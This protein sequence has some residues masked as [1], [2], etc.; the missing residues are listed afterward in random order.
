MLLRGRLTLLALVV[1][2]AFVLVAMLLSASGDEQVAAA[3]VAVSEGPPAPDAPAAPAVSAAR[4]LS[5]RG[6][7][8]AE[9]LAAPSAREEF[10]GLRI[11]DG[12]LE[13]A[14]GRTGEMRLR[15]T[16]DPELSAAVWN[17]LERGRFALAHVVV[18]DPA[19]GAVLAYAST[20][21]E[22]FPPDRTYPAASLVK[23]ITAAAT[24]DRAP[25]AAH[26]TCHF[27]GSPWRLTRE[28]LRSPQR[29]NEADM[30]KAL[31]TSNNQCF[32]RW[33]VHRVGPNALLG[34][35]D[36]FGMLTA[37]A[38]GH[39]GGQAKT[40]SDELALG[41]LGS[42][43][44]GLEIT[45]LHAAQLAATLANGRLVRPRWVA[46]A[47]NADGQRV[48][49]PVGEGGRQVLTPA[50]AAQL[51]GWLV[52]TTVRG[53]ARRAFRVRGG[54][55]L[56]PGISVAGKTGS[57]NG[58]DPKGH[59]EW[60]IGVA[61]ADAPRIAIATVAVQGP[62][63]WWSASQLAAEVLRAT[64]CPRGRCSPDAVDRLRGPVPDAPPVAPARIAQPATA[65]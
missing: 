16:L 15:Y 25:Q 27:L 7:L 63:W 31:A 2:P 60:F 13:R 54:R 65:G 59:Y 42:G 46:E 62:R 24:L 4:A 17:L 49:V 37:P 53:T 34:A 1:L 41:E 57:L 55:P 28:R 6:R 40:P 29:G 3:A 36:R 26:E 23:V 18:M 14:S 38:F 48:A 58:T 45:P 35:I 11:V 21:P 19:T 39:P 5:P 50:L 10:D 12:H 47:W 20:D 9:L 43:L 32:A 52:D 51:R 64:F 22:R 61:P 8:H 30:R 56:L 44:D 33:A